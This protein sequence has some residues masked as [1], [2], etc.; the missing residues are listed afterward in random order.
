MP[1]DERQRVGRQRDRAARR[2]GAVPDVRLVP[3]QDR[4]VP[5]EVACCIAAHIL[6]ACIGSTRV[7]A[8]DTVNSVAG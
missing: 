7:S 5:P 2:P 3:Q 4:P 6:R 8:A 1:R